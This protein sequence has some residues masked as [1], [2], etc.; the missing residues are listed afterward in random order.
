MT[1]AALAASVKTAPHPLKAGRAFP[2]PEA[3]GYFGADLYHSDGPLGKSVRA[4]KSGVGRE[5]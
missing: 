4:R 2:G 5:A 1:D 3:P